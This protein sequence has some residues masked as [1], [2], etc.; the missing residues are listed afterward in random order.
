V[1]KKEEEEEDKREFD[2]D[3]DDLPEDDPQPLDLIFVL[4]GSKKGKD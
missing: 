2:E 1:G 3:K 4:K